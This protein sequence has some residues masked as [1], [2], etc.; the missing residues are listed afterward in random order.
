MQMDR[1]FNFQDNMKMDPDFWDELKMQTEFTKAFGMN[2]DEIKEPKVGEP[3]SFEWWVLA[4]KTNEMTLDHMQKIGPGMVFDCDTITDMWWQWFLSTPKQYNPFAN[5]GSENN[6][7]NA[8]SDTNA[9]LFNQNN[10]QVYFTT[11]SP[12]QEPDFKRIVMTEQAHLL[13]PVYNLVVSPTF[14]TIYENEAKNKV[15]L[16]D[17]VLEDLK[18]INAESVR[19]SVDGKSIY[20]SV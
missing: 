13:V 18:G 7:R 14:Y 12:F 4:G 5:P 20:G 1:G 17:M 2:L 11:V 9:F 3:W 6:E 10:T 19:A 15:S 16:I 8:Y